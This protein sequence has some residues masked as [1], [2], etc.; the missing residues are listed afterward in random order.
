MNKR[1]R[2]KVARNFYTA[3]PVDGAD[4]TQDVLVHVNRRGCKRPWTDRD[5]AML[6]E[7]TRAVLDQYAPKRAASQS[8]EPP[9]A[10]TP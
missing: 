6:T 7:L 3:V 10:G 4:V 9:K 5:Y 1:I 8:G 2:K